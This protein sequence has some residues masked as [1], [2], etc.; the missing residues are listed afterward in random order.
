MHQNTLGQKGEDLA[1]ELFLKK[2]YLIIGRNVFSRFGEIDII[3][4]KEGEIIFCE[5]KTR[6]GARNSFGSPEEAITPWKQQ[7]FLKTALWYLDTYNIPDLVPWR[8]DVI[9]ILVGNGRARIT[10][11]PSAF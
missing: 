10:H 11:Y 1:A 8:C 3:A 4:E 7:R 6:M 5:V 2:G 9:T